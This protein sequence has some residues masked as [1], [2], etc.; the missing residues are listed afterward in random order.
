[1][2][3]PDLTLDV[4][5]SV[6]V[7]TMNRPAALNALSQA[8]FES[9][10]LAYKEINE[11]EDIRVAVLTGAGR[12]FCSGI[13]IKAFSFTDKPR[14]RLNLDPAHHWVGRLFAVQK[15]TIA[16]VNGVSVGGGLA[17]ALAC[18][19]RVASDQA[20]F[21]TRF[22]ALGMPVL[23]G[24]ALLLPRVVG[25]AKAFELL[26][27]AE[28]FDAAAAERMGLVS[29]V[30]PHDQLMDRTMEL[31]QKFAAGPPIA[32]ML[33]KYVVQNSYD[34]SF[35]EHLA[36]QHH[37][38]ILNRMIATHELREAAQAFKERREPKFIGF[39]PPEERK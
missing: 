26:Y 6:A 24:V 25:V 8:M 18:D 5:D 17:L 37:A 7:I 23:D 9:L 14:N 11:R 34:K 1:M 38:S 13:D 35:A 3:Y 22:A 20:R 29:Y 19:I 31:A 4:K 32:Q 28:T 15:P 16:A 27:T 36:Y 30:H 2:D 39:S 33:T 10:E 21:S 12:G